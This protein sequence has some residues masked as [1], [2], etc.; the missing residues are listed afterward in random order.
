MDNLPPKEISDEEMINQAFHELLNDYLNTKHRKKVEIITK[1]FNFANQAHKGIKRRSGEPYIMHPIAVASIVCNEIGLG[2][3][4]ICA[5]L[6]HDVVEDT[7]VTF[8][9]LEKNFSP[10][11]IEGLKL[12]THDKNVD[13]LEYIRKIKN[14]PIARKVKLADLYHNSDPTR[15]ENPTPKDLERKEKYRK[16]I[17][18]LKY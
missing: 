17:E 16:A 6:L 18:I 4:S 3:T 1:A 10:E 8:D 11:V 14:N 5:A 15:M 12:L 13:Y 9:E 7:N 2:S